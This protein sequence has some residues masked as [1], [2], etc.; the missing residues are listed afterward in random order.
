MLNFKILIIL[1]NF[2]LLT[3]ASAGTILLLQAGLGT[4]SVVPP[5]SCDGS[6]DLSTGCTLPML[7][8]L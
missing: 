1:I 7:G 8:I 5:G 2:V 4:S 3:S 6:I